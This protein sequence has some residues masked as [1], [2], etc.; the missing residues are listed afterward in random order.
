MPS[1]QEQN[2]FAV[3]LLKAKK[4]YADE[5]G[6]LFVVKNLS[7]G[8]KMPDVLDDALNITCS[9][10]EQKNAS[11]IFKQNIMRGM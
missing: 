9:V 7:I 5:N 11:I 4:K 2:G 1:L 6:A 8:Y 10:F 3:V